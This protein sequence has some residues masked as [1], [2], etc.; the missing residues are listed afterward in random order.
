MREF[1]LPRGAMPLL[2]LALAGLV[3]SFPRP[4]RI[5]L[6]AGDEPLARGFQAWERAGPEGRSL[7]RWTRDGATLELP[8]TARAERLEARVP[9]AR[10]LPQPI[11]LTWRVNG[12]EAARQTVRPRGWHVESVDLGAIDGPVV[13]EIRSFDDSA[14]LGAAID[15]VELRGVRRLMPRRRAW[16]GLL[17]LVVVAPMMA[18]F[19]AGTRAGHVLGITILVAVPFLL[20][21]DPGRGLATMESAGLPVLVGLTA[22]AVVSRL[23]GEYQDAFA[24]AAVATTV[25]LLALLHPAFYYPDVD[26]HA[27]LLAAIRQDPSLAIDPSPYQQHTGAWMRTIAGTKVAF[28][29]SPVF[30]VTAWP[31]AVF[32]GESGAIKILAALAVGTS[33]LLVHGLAR[34]AGLGVG[35]A[36]LAQCLFAALPIESSRL[37][38]ALFPA[39]FAQALELALLTFLGVR[40]STLGGRALVGLGALAM[41]AQV[42]YTGSLLNVAAVAGVLA[43]ILWA[44]GERGAAVRLGAIVAVT[45]I[46][47][48]LLLYAR[49]LPVLWTQVVPHSGAGTEAGPLWSRT[50]GRALQFLGPYPLLAVMGWAWLRHTATRDVLAA[51]ALAGG[52]LLLLRGPLP[53]LVR[54]V[55]EIELL[56]APTSVFAAAAIARI[57]KT[58]RGRY[59]AVLT[60][61][62]LLAWGAVRAVLAYRAN[63]FIAD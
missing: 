47:V 43:L 36:T 17:L 7:F 18:G 19:I 41:L 10:F 54:D 9:L 52:L 28:P 16:I 57:S 27:R 24:A 45:S 26:T 6:G 30:H 60:A 35:A 61:A 13:L 39:L 8:A 56:A 38:L 5:D 55:K 31:L 14:A 42:A 23:P 50:A 63:L 12:R 53:S 40:L 34:H 49:F 44:R 25:I 62:A 21:L 37:C 20:W 22:L 33:I 59:A 4:T 29:Y 51:A 48:G 32:F 2:T 1:Q 46:V 11:E 58:E 15:W 3:L